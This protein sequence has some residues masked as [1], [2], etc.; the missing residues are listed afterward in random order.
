LIVA[1]L[2]ALLF[3]G[4]DHMEGQ[5]EGGAAGGLPPIRVTTIRPER[6][7]LVRTVELPGR[8]EAFEVAPLYAKVTGYVERMAVDIGDPIKG[9]QGNEPGTVLCEILVPELR[10]E[11]AEKRALVAQAEAQVKQADAAVKLAEATVRSAEAKVR[12]AQAAVAR[13]EALCAR[14]ESEYERVSKLA[15]TGALTKKLVDETKAELAAAEAACKEV[16]ARIAS[17]AAQQQE[18]IAG[19]EKAQADAVAARSRQSVAEAEQRRLEA[20]FGF[21]VIR[22]PFDGVVVER[23]VH[24]GHL[25]QAGAGNGHRPLL[26]VMRIDPVRVFVDVPESDAVYVQA[27][28]KAR[29]KTPSLA[30]EPITGTVTRTSWSLNTTSRTLTA[31][32]DLPN[33]DGRLRPGLYMQV[34]L[35][36]AE[37]ENTLSLPK[38]AIVTQD[39]QTYCFTVGSDGQVARVPVTLGLL[40]GSEFEIR[41]GLDGDENVIGVNAAAFR[42]GQVVERAT[43]TP[44]P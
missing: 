32:V 37:L 31:E 1:V 16:T 25:V 7:T 4:C 43:E 17:V 36:V 18:A 6:K 14:W 33:P 3:A 21:T 9:P 26:T 8:V 2:W 35:V 34:E 29:L 27:G 42:E 22:A 24:T 28:T 13:E 23:N 41:S 5:R 10:E 19:R 11:L 15:E 20:M 40:A 38:I 39:K 44:K 12:E 30:G